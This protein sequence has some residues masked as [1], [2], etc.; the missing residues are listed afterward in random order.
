[1]EVD[2]ADLDSVASA[3]K[4]LL[5]RHDSLTGLVCNAGVMGGPFALSPQGHE[6]Q[7]ATNHLG[8]AALVTALVTGPGRDPARR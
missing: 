3:G 1:M 7:M 5:E 8:H 6:R 2:L 4:T